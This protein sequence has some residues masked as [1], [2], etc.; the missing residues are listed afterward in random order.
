MHLLTGD[1]LSKNLVIIDDVH[2]T[3]KEDITYLKTI[4]K[5][6]EEK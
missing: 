3:A 2:M 5:R 6:I 4:L 1:K